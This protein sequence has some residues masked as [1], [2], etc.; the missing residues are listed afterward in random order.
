MGV[1]PL[2]ELFLLLLMMMMM[3]MVLLLVVQRPGLCKACLP[4]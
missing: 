4:T 2:L 3:I 1:W